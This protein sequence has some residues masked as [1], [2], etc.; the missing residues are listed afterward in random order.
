MDE[1]QSRIVKQFQ[2]GNAQRSGDGLDDTPGYGYKLFFKNREEAIKGVVAPQWNAPRNDPSLPSTEA[3]RQE[4]VRR[5]VRAFL[6][7]SQYEDRPGPIFRRRWFDPEN[8]DEG[9]KDFYDRRSIEKMCWDIVDMAENLHRIGPKAFNCYDPGFQKTVAKTQSLTFS[10][11]MMKLIELFTKYKARCDK[12]FKSS[13]METFVADPETMLWTAQANRD[14]NDK[15]QEFIEHGRVQVKAR[16]RSSMANYR[17]RV[18]E[19]TNF[20][21]V[22]QPANG[23]RNALYNTGSGVLTQCGPMLE[24]SHLTAHDT[25]DEDSVVGV[26][27]V[28]VGN[29][30][31]EADDADTL[32]G[33]AG[34]GDLDEDADVDGEGDTD[35]EMSMTGK[36]QSSDTTKTCPS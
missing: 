7:I 25:D 31:M 28:Q 12:M 19:L 3:D 27:R 21:I 15:R 24:E 35:P 5:L 14:A 2:N 4:W 6:D 32:P 9:Y 11:R 29:T 26:D 33:F 16:K 13:V 20:V 34:R 1:V 10:N 23:F 30:S 8:S 18:P 36:L 22:E 17:R